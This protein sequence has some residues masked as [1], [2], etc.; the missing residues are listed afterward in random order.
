M[1]KAVCGIPFTTPLKFLL[2]DLTFKALPPPQSRGKGVITA[3]IL[4][5]TLTPHLKRVTLVRFPAVL[6]RALSR[7]V[8]VSLE[9]A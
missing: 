1:P 8:N 9:L 5:L 4:I 7:M 6:V 3:V 2:M